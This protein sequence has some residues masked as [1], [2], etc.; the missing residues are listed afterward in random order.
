MDKNKIIISDR[1]VEI[2]KHILDIITH[3]ESNELYISIH[4]EKFLDH[5]L[6]DLFINIMDNSIPFPEDKYRIYKLL[7]KVKGFKLF[8]KDETDN[9][10]FTLYSKNK[11]INFNIDHLISDLDKIFGDHQHIYDS[12]SLSYLH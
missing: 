10:I 5:I 3:S 4:I 1:S 6:Y 2:V 11:D 12:N 9:F 7:K 8:K